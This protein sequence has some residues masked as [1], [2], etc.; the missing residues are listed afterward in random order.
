MVTGMLTELH[1]KN[2]VE[3]NLEKTKTGDDITLLVPRSTRWTLEENH[4][5]HPC[6]WSVL[7]SRPKGFACGAVDRAFSTHSSSAQTSGQLW[8]SQRFQSLYH[9]DYVW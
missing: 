3:E 5:P 1:K 7:E 9:L 8:H 4:R 2:V 6:P